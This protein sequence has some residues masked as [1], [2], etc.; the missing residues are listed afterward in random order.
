MMFQTEAISCPIIAQKLESLGYKSFSEIQTTILSKL[1]AEPDSLNNLIAL[2][3]N[4]SGKSL[5]IAL[6]ISLKKPKSSLI[7][8]PTRE[9]A[10]QLHEYL[11]LIFSDPN[12]NP[13]NKEENNNNNNLGICMIGGLDSKV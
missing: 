1:N 11:S 5:A 7:V 6:Y 12:P 3:P 4:G 2:S 8:A 10:V 9:I 13:N